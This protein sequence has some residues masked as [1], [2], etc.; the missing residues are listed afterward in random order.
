MCQ[1]CGFLQSSQQLGGADTMLTSMLVGKPGLQSLRDLPEIMQPGGSI[2]RIY[3]Q[4]FLMQGKA[5][6]FSTLAKNSFPERLQITA[7]WH[8]E[9]LGTSCIGTWQKPWKGKVSSVARARLGTL[10]LAFLPGCWAVSTVLTLHTSLHLFFVPQCGPR[11][12][13]AGGD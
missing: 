8:L 9:S 5:C 1:G 7:K 2:L 10:Q 6:C 11:A 3:I 12:Y 4:L 13:S